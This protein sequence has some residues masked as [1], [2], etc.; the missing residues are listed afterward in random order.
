MVSILKHQAK[1]V[2]LLPKLG[3]K[4]GGGKSPQELFSN[5]DDPLMQRVKMFFCNLS[6]LFYEDTEVLK[7][8]QQD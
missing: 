2:M 7:A 4:G 6:G 3:G 1:E 5:S 8:L